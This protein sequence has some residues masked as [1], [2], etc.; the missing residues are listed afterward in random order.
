MVPRLEFDFIKADT[1]N[2]VDLSGVLGLLSVKLERTDGND[3]PQNLSAKV[4][5]CDLLD[6]NLDE[7]QGKPLVNHITLRFRSVCCAFKEEAGL[8]CFFD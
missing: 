7:I 2:L 3:L 8:S 1:F 5:E 6:D 4:T